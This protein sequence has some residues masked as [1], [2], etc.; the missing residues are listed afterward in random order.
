MRKFAK[1]IIALLPFLFILN[2]GTVFAY[3]EI[4]KVS[5]DYIEVATSDDG[6]FT[7]GTTGGNP[8]NL[9]DDYKKLLYGHPSPR[10]SYTTVRVDGADYYF[11]G[12][13]QSP[14][15]NDIYKNSITEGVFSDIRVK[16]IL[17]I[18]KNNTTQLKDTIEI[19]YLVTNT[20]N[21]PKNT[22]IRVMMDTMLGNNDSAPFRIPGIGEVTTER[23]FVGDNI[24]SYWQAF[25]NLSSP[26]VIAHGSLLNV[27]IKPDKVQFTNWGRASQSPW[28]F[29]T[30]PGS[31]NG[32]SAVNIYWNEKKLLPGETREYVTYYGLSNFI[33]ETNP[34]VSLN[35]AGPSEINVNGESYSPNPFTITSYI[36]NIS[37]VQADNLQME[38]KLPEGVSMLSGNRIQEVGNLAPGEEKMTSWNFKIEDLK[39]LEHFKIEIMLKGT[40][41]EEKKITKTIHIN[42]VSNP[43]LEDIQLAPDE[44]RMLKGQS[45]SVSVLG[46][47]SDQSFKDLTSAASGTTYSI[48]NEQ[49]A[50]VTNEGV[51]KVL[52]DSPEG[53]VQLT[54]SNSN[55]TTTA[56]VVVES[57]SEDIPR[58]IIA[59]P[60]EITL[61]KGQSYQLE[62]LAYYENG[63]QQ[64]ITADKN[65]HYS[66]L[67]ESTAKVSSSGLVTTEG[68]TPGETK[69]K[70]EYK[71][72][73]KEIVVKVIGEPVLSKIEVSPQKIELERGKTQQIDVN[74]IMSN[75]ETKDVTAEEET[76]YKS[77]DPNRATVSSEGLI[78]V[79]P[80]APLG[81]VGVR[82]T[83]GGKSETVTVKVLSGST[84]DSIVVTSEQMELE[85]GKMTQIGV[86]AVMSTGE[87]KDVTTEEGTTYKSYD[88]NRVMVSSEGLIQVLPNAPLGD[89]GVR[90]THGGKS[91]TVTVKVVS[92]PTLNSMT[93]TPAQI[94]LERG[95]T[96]QIGV[97]AVMSTGETKD[98]TSEEGTTYKSY[99]PNRATVSNEGLIQVLPNAPLGDVGIRVTRGRKT[100]TVM[101]KILSGPTLNSIVVTPAQMELERGKT[102]QIAV[103]AMMS[104]GE[105]KDVTAEEGPTYKSYDL[106]RATVSSEGLIQ[107]LPN[108]PLGDVGIRVTYGGKSQNL[109]IKVLSGL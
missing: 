29:Y 57:N 99:D 59:W 88:P 89:V 19:K 60:S 86:T 58:E 4:Q 83:H 93:V 98:V 24:P 97:T 92:E 108:A 49:I 36:Q 107:I 103:T 42:D 77:Y 80:N 3:S 78:Q 82:V 21:V 81:D 26:T 85:R 7:I 106:N 96:T 74:A 104:N 87:T 102:K 39:E 109:S 11:A 64:N 44:I 12:N 28:D 69:L 41:I 45:K 14:V 13:V 27:P 43:V 9:L 2:I 47:Y 55:F 8:E 67:N 65:V 30:L 76:T 56:T 94:Q 101:V 61:E 38:I 73:T 53:S 22:G 15:S 25:D 33:S 1:V 48:D 40:N 54:A 62:A 16:Q 5:N 17:S 37:D 70:I 84:L 90:V 18:V 31:S 95:K 100:Q 79:L 91:Q 34:P 51:I 35:I 52:D 72:L 71:G 46:Y 50:T 32:D 20:G 66:S 75:G 105:T 10:T 63:V 23:E 6:R 68:S